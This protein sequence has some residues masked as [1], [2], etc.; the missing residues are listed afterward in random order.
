MRNL[1][2]ARIWKVEF[3]NWLGV[4]RTEILGDGCHHGLPT[5]Q[6]TQRMRIRIHSHAEFPLPVANKGVGQ[7]T[8]QLNRLSTQFA[9]EK[10]LDTHTHVL[11]CMWV[12]M[13]VGNRIGL[14]L[15]HP[16]T[17]AHVSTLLWFPFPLSLH[18]VTPSPVIHPCAFTPSSHVWVCLLIL[19]SSL[20]SHL[21]AVSIRFGC[22]WY[23]LEFGKG[24]LEL[25][26]KSCEILLCY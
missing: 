1:L 2:I 23:V 3:S 20:N 8:C 10:E 21:T 13:W 15:P 9:R 12:W 7:E 18:P 19:L 16:P 17:A 14:R 4:S 6:Q 11:A 24:C 26:G 22:E 25:E 5:P